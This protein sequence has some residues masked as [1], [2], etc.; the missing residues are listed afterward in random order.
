MPKRRSRKTRT[1]QSSITK[2]HTRHRSHNKRVKP[3]FKL[4]RT[5]FGILL[6]IFLVY[7]G[8]LDYI[9]R[10]EFEGKRWAIPA[11]VYARPLE[12]YSGLP[13]NADKFLREL[14]LLGYKQVQGIPKTQAT[15]TY[16]DYEFMLVTRPF[17]F[18]DVETGSETIRLTINSESI[19]SI[20][21]LTTDK[22]IDLFRMEPAILG[23]IYP[24]HNEDRV[25]VKLE[26]VPTLLTRA[27]VAVEDKNFYSHHGL[28]FKAIARAAW[29]NLLARA[30]VE[31]GSTITQQLVKNYF[32]T[33]TRSL[34]RKFNEAIMSVLLEIHYD[35][36]EI[37]ESYINEI[38]LGQDRQRAIHGFALASQYYFDKPINS[39]ELDEIVILVALIRG[40]SYY[41]PNKKSV[42]LKKRRNLV[43]KLLEKQNIISHAN[44]QKISA[45]PL[46]I[47][48][49]K[50]GFV[51]ANPD[52]INLVKRQLR[53]YY[54]L[55]DLTSEGL[56]IF[57][58]MDPLIQHSL[59]ESVKRQLRILKSH[60]SKTDPLQVAAIIS[61]TST[62]EIL[63]LTGGR[64]A[65]FA[66][67]NRAID[68]KRPIGSLIKPGIYLAA[69]RSGKYNL[70]ST[71]DDKTIRLRGQDK[72][73]WQPDNYDLKEHG[74]VPFY[75]SLIKSFNLATVRLGL[76]VGFDKISDTLNRLGVERNIPAYPSILL[77]S[78]E[79]TPIEVAKM[80]Q[81]LAATGFQTPL[82]SI[83]AVM[84]ADGT[85]L[86]RFPV[87]VT[88]TLNATNVMQINSILQANA[89]IGTASLI[90]RQLPDLN[91]AGKTGTTNDLR[92]SWFAGFSGRHLGV[93]WMGADKNRSIGL[94]GSS[95]AL[96]IWVDVFKKIKT[97]PLSLQA[98]E[99]IVE[100]RLDFA[101]GRSVP[102][103]CGNAISLM[104]DSN[105]T[106]TKL[107]DCPAN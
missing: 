35:K 73:I 99:G 57:S 52:Y 85:V 95:G 32:L 65:T 2:R 18:P 36:N 10:S 55:Q 60:D 104:I 28:D 88:Q 14:K 27:I 79:L 81:T 53:Q 102:A 59:V 45:Q 51:T 74:E 68:A 38:Y 90:A 76:D 80:Y 77:G 87:K 91:A 20:T 23:G 41:D 64:H 75:Y 39:L 103:G 100:Y 5:W 31:G 69:L 17:R 62:G 70:L 42:R 16:S 25:L 48:K 21:S 12:L 30:A 89:K 97:E 47:Q 3:W 63:A 9:I 34:W 40:P 56:K 1:N 78:L 11:T 96:K 94:T 66:G 84:T 33:N 101:S 71:L 8:Y 46:N 43:L 22:Q 29:R 98:D 54:R 49:G 24:A 67:F 106:V 50:P 61:D 37:L 4:Y 83:R 93:V 26:Q 6:T 13:I 82:Q 58:S 15:F 86:S 7:C 105:V 19:E 44:V 92:D 107:D 72:T